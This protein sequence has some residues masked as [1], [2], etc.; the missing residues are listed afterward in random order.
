MDQLKIEFHKK[1]VQ[2]SYNPKATIRQVIASAGVA[3]SKDPHSIRLMY[4]PSDKQAPIPLTKEGNTVQDYEIPAGATLRVKDLGPQ[5]GYRTVFLAE[6]LGPL[7]IWWLVYL[8]PV[9][10]YHFYNSHFDAMYFNSYRPQPTQLLA[11][12][13]WTLHYGKRLFESVFIH[14]FS[15]ATMP[16][17][18]LFKNCIYYWGFAF[19]IA[20]V[21]LHPD[22]TA[23]NF[24]L[25]IVGLGI[26]CTCEICNFM[27]IFYFFLYFLHSLF[28]MFFSTFLAQ[29]PQAPCIS[30]RRWKCN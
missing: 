25:Q 4:Q 18:N 20:Y 28:F 6:Y 1:V 19:L 15:H 9:P 17:F 30:P 7:S 2:V 16:L 3:L 14:K 23:P 27:F 10:I 13:L 24:I 29:M 26:F 12:L 22:Y 8:F 5:I 21:V 11:T